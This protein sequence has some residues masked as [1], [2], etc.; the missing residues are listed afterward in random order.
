[1]KTKTQ[2]IATVVFTSLAI[3]CAAGPEWLTRDVVHNSNKCI[4]PAI[5]AA[6]IS[7]AASIGTK[8]V[9]SA[10]AKK[11]GDKAIAYQKDKEKLLQNWYDRE[12]NADATQRADAQQALTYASE[13]MK[14]RNR[15][16]QGR[17][18]V[19][20]STEEAVA[21][22]KAANNK[23][24]SDIVSN[25]AAAGAKRKDQISDSYLSGKLNQNDIMSNIETG[26]AGNIF[27]AGQN[28]SSNNLDIDSIANA[29]E[30]EK[31]S[32]SGNSG[33]EFLDTDT[34]LA[35]KYIDDN[36]IV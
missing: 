5:I 12:Y 20:G 19:M 32:E 17:A 22:E 10:K 30:K 15:S 6:I 18:A 25:I 31:D 23:V 16:A 2:I 1:M 27:K 7:A 26:R 4:A 34:D 11:A 13:L 8:A 24:Y 33:Q 14:Q 28:A 36:N 3:L 21:A 9:S 29:F 35:K